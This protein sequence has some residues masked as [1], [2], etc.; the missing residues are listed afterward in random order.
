MTTPGPRIPPLPVEEYQALERELFGDAAFTGTMHVGRTWAHNPG[1]MKA[2]RP[3][4]EY[5]LNASSLPGRDREL[6]ILRIVWRRGS[7]YAFGQHVRMGRAA[8]LTD[9]EIDRVPH[10]P[11]ADGW[12]AFQKVL[13]Q[14]V[15]ELHDEG[16]L[17]DDTW[18]ALARRYEDAQL[19]DLIAVVGRYWAVAVMLNSVGVQPEPG[20]PGFPPDAPQG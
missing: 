10:G 15:D 18:Q 3:L 7:E 4:Q 16:R 5:L 2:Q 1:L 12:T 13:L 6:A 9:A 11:D 17:S 20:L 19:I 14:A 8:G